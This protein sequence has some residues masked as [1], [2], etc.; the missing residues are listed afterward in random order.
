M[1]EESDDKESVPAVEEP[2]ELETEASTTGL[3]IPG[4]SDQVDSASK[5][6]P[7]KKP[8]PPK[9]KEEPKPDT[10]FKNAFEPSDDEET[11]Q[12]KPSR[13]SGPPKIRIVEESASNVTKMVRTA[14]VEEELKQRSL[15]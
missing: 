15:S 1:A 13:H 11:N 2:A 8:E 10:A 4:F 14:A 7:D 9:K 6:P 3:F 5:S 12:S